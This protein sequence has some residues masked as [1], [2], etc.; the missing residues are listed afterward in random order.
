MHTNQDNHY[1]H[2]TTSA[3]Q[4]FQAEQY[5]NN[6]DPMNIDDSWSLVTASDLHP[7]GKGLEGSTL[8]DATLCIVD[9]DMI[10]YNADEELPDTHPKELDETQLPNAQYDPRFF[11]HSEHNSSQSLDCPMDNPLSTSLVPQGI[12]EKLP[13]TSKP[14]R[15]VSFADNVEYINTSYSAG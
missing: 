14:K 11:D 2:S 7:E 1:N 6:D 12:N 8:N 3:E 5:P 13:G 10:N 15:V 9:T 4:N